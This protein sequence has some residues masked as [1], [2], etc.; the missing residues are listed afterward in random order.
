LNYIKS[1]LDSVLKSIYKKPCIY[2]P[3][4]I[5]YLNLMKDILPKDTLEKIIKIF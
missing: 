3:L 5:E 4:I 1:L 2:G